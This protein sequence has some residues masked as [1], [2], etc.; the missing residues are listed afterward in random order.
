[1]YLKCALKNRDEGDDGHPWGIFFF[2]A[3]TSIFWFK[4]IDTESK[5]AKAKSDYWSDKGNW[6]DV[7]GILIMF[8]L[9]FITGFGIGWPSQETLRVLAAITTCINLTRLIDWMRLFDETAF[10]VLLI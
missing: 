5:Q 9:L 6:F 1:M 7:A 3:F 2:A 10:Y 4:Q 8:F